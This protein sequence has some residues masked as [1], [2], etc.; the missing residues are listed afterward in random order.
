M[1]RRT[2]I[3][4]GRRMVRGEIP[5]QGSDRPR[6]TAAAPKTETTLDDLLELASRPL[7][8]EEEAEE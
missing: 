2:G 1:S 8:P 7:E 6:E 5:R 3:A 4:F